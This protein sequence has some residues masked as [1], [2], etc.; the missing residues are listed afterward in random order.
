MAAYLL[1]CTFHKKKTFHYKAFQYEIS[2]RISYLVALH[3]NFEIF[4]KKKFNAEE[5]SK[6]EGQFANFQPIFNRKAVLNSQKIGESSFEQSTE[7]QTP[8][9]FPLC[10]SPPYLYC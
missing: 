2:D 9:F 7:L 8:Y 4:R 10:H 1:T 5:F 3:D 6:I